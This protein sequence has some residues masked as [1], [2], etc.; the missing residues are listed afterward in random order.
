MQE[1]LEKE[2]E[3]AAKP[4]EEKVQQAQPK[5]EE[6]KKLSFKEKREFEELDALIPQLE[7]EKANLE[8]EL[9]SGTLSTDELLQKSN[10]ISQL[11]EA[12]EEKTMRWLELSELA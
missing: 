6:K 11:I 9:S 1:L 2:K 10:R 5:N 8:N 7:E 12:I 4:K 3:Q